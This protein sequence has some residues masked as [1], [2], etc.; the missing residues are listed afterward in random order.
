ML[1]L[2]SY[3]VISAD[4][5]SVWDFKK[6]TLTISSIEDWKKKYNLK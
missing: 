5:I 2:E 1:N 3:S 6:N 4:Y